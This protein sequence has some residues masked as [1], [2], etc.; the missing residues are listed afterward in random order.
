MLGG[1]VDAVGRG[2]TLLARTLKSDQVWQDSQLRS[3]CQVTV[4]WPS[5]LRSMPR[6]LSNMYHA[7]NTPTVAKP[8]YAPTSIH[9]NA[10][11][12]NPR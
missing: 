5:P 4:V 9:L 12:R 1:R 10:C 11:G 2:S 8:T 3:W 6:K 7:Q